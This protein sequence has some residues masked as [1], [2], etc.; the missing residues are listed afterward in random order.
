MWHV[1]LMSFLF[2]FIECREYCNLGVIEESIPGSTVNQFESNNLIYTVHR[3][4]NTNYQTY[5]FRYPKTIDVLLAGGGGSG[6]GTW[7]DFFRYPVGG[8]MVTLGGNGAGGGGGGGR[9]K[10]TVPF[11][12]SNL[13]GSITFKVG[14]GHNPFYPSLNEFSTRGANTYVDIRIF[15]HSGTSLYSFISDGGSN[16]GT[17][18]LSGFGGGATGGGGGSK[19][20]GGEPLSCADFQGWAN[21]IWCAGNAWG[22]NYNMW[23]GWKIASG[24]GGVGAYGE[25]AY[26]ATENLVVTAKRAGNG[27][28]GVLFNFFTGMEDYLGG[29][30]GGGW[31]E[32]DSEAGCAVHGG[33]N[34]GSPDTSLCRFN[35]RVSNTGQ[36]MTFFNGGNG[37]DGTGGGGGGASSI[38]ALSSTD[39][40]LKGYGGKGGNGIVMLR[41]FCS[42]CLP[43]TFYDASQGGCVQCQAGKY[44]TSYKGN[45]SSTCLNCLAGK[46]NSLHGLSYCLQCVVGK[47][48]TS[49]GNTFCT[50]CNVGTYSLYSF[51]ICQTCFHGKYVWLDFVDNEVECLDCEKGFFSTGT[52]FTTCN[53]CSPGTFSIEM[54]AVNSGV[55]LAC[56]T[57]EYSV[58]GYSSCSTCN[59]GKYVSLNYVNNSVLCLQCGMGKY[60][61][62]SGSLLCDFCLKG[63]YSSMVGSSSSALCFNCVV[64]FYSSYVGSSH[65]NSC[66]SG[67]YSSFRGS[68]RCDYCEFGKYSTEERAIASATCTACNPGT[69]ASISGGSSC[70]LCVAGKYFTGYHADSSLV[71]TTCLYGKYS[72]F[73]GATSSDSCQ[74]CENGLYPISVDRSQ[75]F[76]CNT[77]SWRTNIFE[78]C[79]LCERGKYSSAI[80]AVNQSTCLQCEAGKYSSL[81]GASICDFCALGKFIATKGST[82][83]KDCPTFMSTDSVGQ[84]FCSIQCGYWWDTSVEAIESCPEDHYCN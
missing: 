82:T 36:P 53:F 12:V 81:D 51:T 6:G 43:G 65:C 34:G 15:S 60:V 26:A 2:Y 76:L 23:Q 24:G 80:G 48:L 32:P 17:P 52:G 33:G 7:T 66:I 25:G 68:S 77:G 46:F 70:T 55:C 11:T 83:C 47:Y 31:A 69:Y 41:Y 14:L 42:I 28:R 10:I 45:S 40:S 57:G 30:G 38:N 59:P 4:S 20:Q 3:M 18:D 29:G 63:Q 78:N 21:L 73:T 75:C 62:A 44:A 1:G 56:N 22:G 5:N 49:N 64:G 72:T 8:V 54:G 27:G 19:G 58:Y 71:C 50:S 79:W 35:S 67:T 16:G 13:G 84:T 37:T 9:V 39:S 61:S 74:S